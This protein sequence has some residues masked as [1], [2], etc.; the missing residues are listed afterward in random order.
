MLSEAVS[1]FAH[2][3]RP[4]TALAPDVEALLHAAASVAGCDPDVKEQ[5]RRILMPL[6]REDAERRSDLTATLRAYYACGARI[7]KTAEKLFLHRN[8]VRYRLDRVVAL[9]RLD[10]DAPAVM[11]AILFA[12]AVT[13]AI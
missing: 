6:A 4:K 2:D 5:C 3:R 11:A 10:I 13:D 8:S 12:L 7:D 1:R 9:L